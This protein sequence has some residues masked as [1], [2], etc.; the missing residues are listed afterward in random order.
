MILSFRGAIGSGKTT[1]AN[2]FV[3][4]FNF[5]RVSFADPL[6]MEVFDFLWAA[7]TDDVWRQFRSQTG[8]DYALPSPAL[9]ATDLYYISPDEKVRWINDNKSEVGPLL[10]WWGTEYRRNGTS[11]FYWI[12]KFVASALKAWQNNRH[13]VV[14]DAR[15]ENELDM[16]CS[17]GGKHIYILTSRAQAQSEARSMSHASERLNDPCDSRHWTAIGNF[18]TQS[19]FERLLGAV[20]NV[21]L[22]EPH[23]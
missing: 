3:N 5:Q 18:G 22:S 1:A 14:D 7:G 11:E 17:L 10:Q 15:F 19:E 6:K 2:Y 13:V 23:A 9:G 20:G 21:L 12:Q 4:N 16:V 8:I